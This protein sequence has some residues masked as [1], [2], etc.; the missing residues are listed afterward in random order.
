MSRSRNSSNSHLCRGLT[1]T[2]I[3]NGLNQNRLSCL[4]QYGLGRPQGEQGKPLRCHGPYSRKTLSSLK[5][6]RTDTG[7][8]GKPLP[9]PGPSQPRS[10]TT[11]T[12]TL[13]PWPS[14]RSGSQSRKMTQGSLHC[15][16]S[17]IGMSSCLPF[18]SI[19]ILTRSLDPA[20]F[21]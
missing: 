5:V 13:T 3:G 12:M 4:L 6:G 21:S 8:L 14:W 18:S 10:K 9:N 7:A 19:L 1:T 17:R 20:E 11:L 15:C 2:V 16:P